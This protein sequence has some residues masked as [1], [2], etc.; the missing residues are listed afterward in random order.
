MYK[1]Q[2]ERTTDTLG[3]I[4][5]VQSYTRVEHEVRGMKKLGDEVLSAQL[6]VLSWWALAT[7]IT[8]TATTLTILAILTLGVWFYVRGETTVGD[9]VMFMSYA[10][11]LIG[12]GDW[13]V[14]ADPKG[15]AAASAPFTNWISG[16][17][18]VEP[19]PGDKD[20]FVHISAV[21]QAGFSTLK[22]GQ[23]VAFDLVRD[24][25]TGKV[26]AGQLQAV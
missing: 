8:R 15:A 18:K 13:D 10:T 19:L 24:P 6:P 23:K 11:L 4:A 7:V 25:R 17:G 26:S 14:I 5:L 1:R 16:G 22:D 2:A 20:V 12:K 9:I 21:E 3:N